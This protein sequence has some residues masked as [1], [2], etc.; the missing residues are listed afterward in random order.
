LKTFEE[1]AIDALVLK[2]FDKV[3]DWTKE[4]IL[5]VSEPFN[6]YGYRNH[7]WENPYLWSGTQYYHKG[8]YVRDGVY[9][10]NAVDQQVGVSVLLKLLS[11]QSTKPQ[12]SRDTLAAQ[13]I[14]V[15]KKRGYKIFTNPG[16]CNIVYL[17]G[18]KRRRE[19]ERQQAQCLQRSENRNPI[20]ERTSSYRREMGGNYGAGEVLDRKPHE[21]TRGGPY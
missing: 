16:E 5:F 3:S 12:P 7:G 19:S 1:A 6:G 18:V 2:Q 4:K 11:G 14:S 10:P 17:E 15:M 8:K 21:R 9:D 20:Q 13:I